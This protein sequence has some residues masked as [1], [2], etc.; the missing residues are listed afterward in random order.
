M[1]NFTE[2]KNLKSSYKAL[3][4]LFSLIY[5]W[6]WVNNSKYTEVYNNTIS[7]KLPLIITFI[8]LGNFTVAKF[9]GVTTHSIRSAVLA[10]CVYK[11]W[12]NR[13]IISRAKVKKKIFNKTKINY[14]ITRCVTKYKHS[15]KK[16]PLVLFLSWILYIQTRSVFVD[17]SL[18]HTHTHRRG[19]T[20][21]NN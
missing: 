11:L 12:K 18:T 17:V 15:S 13:I 5:S 21:W 14:L 16:L 2:T 6:K 10:D 19:Q 20:G 4:T 3:V 8:V 9:S 1:W 7:V